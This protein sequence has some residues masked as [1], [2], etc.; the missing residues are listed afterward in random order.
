M[1]VTKTR[2]RT[3]SA[4]D[5]ANSHC[6]LWGAIDIQTTIAKKTVYDSSKC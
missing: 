4:K 1:V 2:G 6:R 3:Y 5:V